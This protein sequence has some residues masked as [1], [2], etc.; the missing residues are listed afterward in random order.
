[1][2]AESPHFVAADAP[3]LILH[4]SGSTGAPKVIQYS[5]YRLN[6]F[7]HWQRR[8]FP[9]FPDVPATPPAPRVNALPL[10]HFGGLSF[11]LQALLDG[12]LVHLPR[13]IAPFDYLRLAVRERC[14]LLMLVPAL[15][16]ALL[17]DAA[18]RLPPSTLRYCLTMGEAVTPQLIDLVCGRLGVRV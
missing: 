2:P 3:V 12:R 6:V 5:R 15:Y 17:A 14:Q 1:S 7:L 13:A 16:D 18:D 11:V 8:L 4:S 10:A 9:A